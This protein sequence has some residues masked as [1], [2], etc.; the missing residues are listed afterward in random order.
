MQDIVTVTMNPALDVSSTTAQVRPTSKLRCQNVQRHPGGGGIN[1]ARVL[2]RLGAPCL[3]IFPVGGSTGQLLSQLLDAEGV[4]SLGVP[5]AG[6]VRESFTVRDETTQQEYRFV[7]PGPELSEAEWRACLAQI[8]KSQTTPRYLVGSGSLPPGV[9]VNFYATLAQQAAASGTQFIVDTSGPALAAALARGVYMVKPSLRE[10]R[11]ITQAPLT[12]M[13]EAARAARGWVEA[14]QAA[15]VVV[16][17]GAQ[18]ALLVSADEA[19]Y[20]PPI[21]VKVLS[22]VGA[23]DSFVAGMAWA[24]AQGKELAPAFAYG[25]ACGTAALM[26]TGTGLCEAADAHRLVGQVQLLRELPAH[27]I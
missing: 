8:A 3:A 20:A 16:S 21:A 5:V 2:H 14:G 12:T 26:S 19:V 7:L 17:M 4:P 1:V 9:P 15:V 27:S 13:A 23:G 22:A 11:E 18:G 25:V 6:H 24:L 10:I